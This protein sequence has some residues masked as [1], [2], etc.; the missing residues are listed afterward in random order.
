MAADRFE[1]VIGDAHLGELRDDGMLQAAK[2]PA[3]ITIL[4]RCSP[5]PKERQMN[6][7]LMCATLVVGLSVGQTLR[8]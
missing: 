1:E 8:E 2:P 6:P 7:Y 5:F 4:P 3:A